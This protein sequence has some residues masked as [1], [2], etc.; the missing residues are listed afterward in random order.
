ML[1]VVVEMGSISIFDRNILFA[2]S[3]NSLLLLPLRIL[4]IKDV[5]R[6]SPRL[7]AHRVGLG[8]RANDITN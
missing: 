8:E 5:G 3:T 7:S 6:S 2:L 1:K 4:G